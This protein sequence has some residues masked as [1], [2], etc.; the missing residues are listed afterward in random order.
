[1]SRVCDA[2]TIDFVETVTPDSLAPSTFGLDGDPVAY[3]ENA[4]KR[5]SA[6]LAYLETLT[7]GDSGYEAA[8]YQ[9][10]LADHG[11]K[12]AP[13]DAAKN[14][15]RAT[16]TSEEAGLWRRM[17]S[18]L[19]IE[20]WKEVQM[21]PGEWDWVERE[22]AKTRRAR[23]TPRVV[24][25]AQR[26]REEADPR[27]PAKYKLSSFYGEDFNADQEGYKLK[28]DV[29]CQVSSKTGKYVKFLG[30]SEMN[31]ISRILLS[32]R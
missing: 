6:A 26:D 11:K 5:K 10:H 20:C 9:A 16:V 22:L 2:A 19:G 8:Y 30:L 14:G 25:Q 4:D 29:A 15:M 1:M 27:Y 17:C 23:G 31:I 21:T 24:F 13:R 12:I 7:P 32:N 18:E 28:G 3:K